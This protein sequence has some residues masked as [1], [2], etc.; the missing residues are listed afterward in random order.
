[1]VYNYK[2]SP[3]LIEQLIKIHIEASALRALPKKESVS[4]INYQ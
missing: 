3:S 4:K 1:M 2:Q